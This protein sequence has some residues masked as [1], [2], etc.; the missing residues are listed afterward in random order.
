MAK[1]A[2]TSNAVAR[3]AISLT[4]NADSELLIIASEHSHDKPSTI[5]I[6]R[7]LATPNQNRRVNVTRRVTEVVNAGTE[8]ESLETAFI[9][10]NISATANF[11]DAT[12]K[13][14]EDDVVGVVAT[15]C[16]QQARQFGYIDLEAV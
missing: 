14:M 8:L 16:V 10:Y 3:E 1:L 4:H 5:E 11:P 12:L 15:D 7:T 2:F 9:K 6:K 13:A